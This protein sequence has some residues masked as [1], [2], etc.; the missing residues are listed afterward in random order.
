VRGASVC[1]MLALLLTSTGLQTRPPYLN[2]ATSSR[3]TV[4]RRHAQMSAEEAAKAAWLA[5]LDEPS[6]S[7]QSPS[8]APTTEHIPAASWLVQGGPVL[9]LEAADHMSSVA[10]REASSRAFS[11]VSV[12]VLDAG[13]RLIVAKT[14][15]GCG[16]L[17]PDL[18]IAKANACIG[19]HCSSRELRDKYV[20][21]EGIGP[22]MPQVLSFGIVAAA[23]NQAIGPFPGGV[24]CRDAAH[25][26]VCAIG[27]SGAASDED[28]HCAIM[29]AQSV[30]LLTEPALSKLI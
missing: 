29:A 11:P 27:V 18:A 3:A 2:V 15:L 17:T 10:L 8:N 16:R 24:L 9:T 7:A 12:C 13:G 22:K 21:D 26:V 28:E 23:A 1:G 14:M 5:K 25:N 20:N 6:W 30:G 4:L 19:L